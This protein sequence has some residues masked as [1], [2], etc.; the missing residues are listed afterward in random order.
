M[1]PLN[2]TKLWL[3]IWWDAAWQAEGHFVDAFQCFWRIK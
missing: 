1:I 3:D 2:W